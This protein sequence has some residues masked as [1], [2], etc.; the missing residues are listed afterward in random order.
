M[1]VLSHRTWKN[2]VEDKRD[3]YEAMGV[4][5][6]WLFDPYNKYLDGKRLEGYRLRD[7]AYVP[8]PPQPDGVVSS[9]VLGLDL[10]DADGELRLRDPATGEDLLT[11]LEQRKALKAAEERIAELE[12]ALR[13]STDDPKG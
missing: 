13:R 12:R 9:A 11:N 3:K 6:F 7:G 2:D 1:E 8:L 4:E 10:R 5:E